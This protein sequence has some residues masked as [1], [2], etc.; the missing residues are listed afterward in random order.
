MS[1]MCYEIIL[2]SIVVWAMSVVR[3]G[4]F[5]ELMCVSLS[6]INFPSS[7]RLPILTIASY[8]GWRNFRREPSKSF[9]FLLWIGSLELYTRSAPF[10]SHKSQAKMGYWMTCYLRGWWFSRNYY[11]SSLPA[12]RIG[13]AEEKI[14][15]CRRLINNWDSGRIGRLEYGFSMDKV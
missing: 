9:F 14:L 7:S 13:G 3:L 8:Q 5:N 1:N 6:E 4:D 10:N 2:I 12:V 11:T 15:L